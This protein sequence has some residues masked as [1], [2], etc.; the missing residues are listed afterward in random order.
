MESV[1]DSFIQ[2]RTV[3]FGDHDWNRVDQRT[4]RIRVQVLIVE[5]V[6]ETEESLKDAFACAFKFGVIHHQ[7]E[8]K[9]PTLLEDEIEHAADAEDSDVVKLSVETCRVNPRHTFHIVDIGNQCFWDLAVADLGHAFVVLVD[10]VV[11]DLSSELVEPADL[12]SSVHP[13]EEGALADPGEPDEQE[14]VGEYEIPFDFSEGDGVVEG[15][16]NLVV[17]FRIGH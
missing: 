8:R 7:N 3:R 11:I 12:Q 15:S 4:P 5:E 6:N 9:A 16:Q 17:L 1:D 2:F 13:V 14:A 10:R